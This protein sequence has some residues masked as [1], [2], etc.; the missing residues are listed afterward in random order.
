METNVIIC[1]DCLDFMRDMPDDSVDLCLCDPP[2]G[3]GA[4]SSM[5]KVSGMQPG[6]AAAPKGVYPDTDWDSDP[7]EITQFQ[8]IQWISKNQIIFGFNHF[9]D[10]FPPSPCAIV[11]D[12]NNG[13][14][15][16]AD[17]E[18][19]WGSFK[20]AARL[21]KY[22][23]NGMIQEN[24]ACKEY[25]FHPTQK[26]LGVML[27]ILERYSKPNDLI[28]DPFCGSGSTCV[29]AKRLG[30]RYIGV[31]ISPEY[32]EIARKR[33]EA[34]EKGITVKELEKGQ[35]SLFTA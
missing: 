33:L 13:D 15:N 2:Y 35:G 25:R 23:W 8:A 19:A 18:I 14:N 32:C 17:C 9:S 5:H 22:T 24:M 31:D 1:G 21:V 6:K 29:A 7:F 16:F 34:E 11:W 4:D 26:P 12:K 30:R 10:I 3:I 27:W 20:T 28:F